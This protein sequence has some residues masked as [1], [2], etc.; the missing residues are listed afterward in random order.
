M[1]L[2]ERKLED[3]CQKILH[4]I[5]QS[6]NCVALR[7]EAP[8]LESLKKT[9]TADLVREDELDDEVRTILDGH[10]DEIRKRGA[11]YHTLFRKTKQM[12]ARERK[13]VV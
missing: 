11:D 8:I 3:L 1:R 5:S 4:A 10:M 12:L 7:A 2:S 9:L 13:I 6:N